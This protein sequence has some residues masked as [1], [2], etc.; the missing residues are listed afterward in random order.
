V[1][2]PN[3]IPEASEAGHIRR[4]TFPQGVRAIG[5][6]AYVWLIPP[7]SDTDLDAVARRRSE[8]AQALSDYE[9]TRTTLEEELQDLALTE[10]VLLRLDRLLHAEV[11]AAY[12]APSY[13]TVTAEPLHVRAMGML[14][15]F[16]PGRGE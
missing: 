4:R 10:R 9:A 12:A 11:R 16:I 3:A 14:K 1:T 6:A 15:S 5:A 13:V 2:N 7:M 8:I